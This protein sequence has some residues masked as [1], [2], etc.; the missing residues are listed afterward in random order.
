MT[1]ASK[2]TFVGEPMGVEGN[3]RTTQWC[4]VMALFGHKHAA[5]KIQRIARID[6]RLP[7]NTAQF[8]LARELVT[9]RTPP[10]RKAAI[11]N[12][13]HDWHQRAVTRHWWLQ[14]QWHRSAQQEAEASPEF[15]EVDQRLFAM[16]PQFLANEFETNLIDQWLP[17]QSVL[18]GFAPLVHELPPRD[19]A[20]GRHAPKQIMTACMLP[21][22]IS[23]SHD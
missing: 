23:G 8:R 5:G 14:V 15:D 22:R 21:R 2:C 18:C 10:E 13:Q 12:A 7:E 20:P 6:L 17:V 3:E 16:A 1:V 9:E 11:A 19:R 4:N